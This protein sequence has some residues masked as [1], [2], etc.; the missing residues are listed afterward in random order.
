VSLTGSILAIGLILALI[1]AF[2]RLPALHPVQLWLLVWSLS[3]ALYALR[4]LPYIGI[5][6]TTVGLAGGASLAFV[7]TATVSSRWRCQE[8]ERSL[9]A[10]LRRTLSRAAIWVLVVA[11]VWLAAYLTQVVVTY[12]LSSI[13]R[14]SVAAR[15]GIQKGEFSITIKYIY[16]MFAAI[17]LTAYNGAL[18]PAGRSRRRWIGVC[19]LCVASLYVAT[20]R[21]TVVDGAIAGT[22]TYALASPHRLRKQTVILAAIGLGVLALGV[23]LS[24]GAIIGKTFDHNPG[25]FE[26]PNI[27]AR[28]RYLSELALPYQYASAPIAALQVQV[29]S[30]S[31][32][33]DGHGCAI[34]PSA[35]SILGKIGIA[36]THIP[37]IRAFTAP[38]LP[39]N[40]YTSLDAPLIDGGKALLIPIFALIGS[41]LGLLWSSAARGNPLAVIFY[42]L[43]TVALVTAAGSFNFTAPQLIGAFLIA[44]LALGLAH[45]SLPGVRFRRSKHEP[46]T[47]QTAVVG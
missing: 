6:W 38:P 23:F 34:L 44:A 30:S 21:A 39:W 40:T 35:C 20:G 10:N 46:T 41:L 43:E 26:V 42:G 14:T 2:W 33:G 27:F 15:E 12:G 17:A 16:L 4:L 28:H 7:V 1:A 31:L 47:G 9:S 32:W 13:S 37:R 22:V 36:V 8:P 29:H 25:F 45:L 5:S 19:V 3:T 18:S 11:A 24:L